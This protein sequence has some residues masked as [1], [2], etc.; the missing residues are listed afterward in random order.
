MPQVLNGEN[1]INT[2]TLEP[3]CSGCGRTQTYSGTDR[4][5]PIAMLQNST[6]RR[7]Q[8]RAHAWR[9]MGSHKN[10]SGT[11]A[12][13]DVAIAMTC[14]RVYVC[15]LQESRRQRR[16]GLVASVASRSRKRRKKPNT[17]RKKKMHQPTKSQIQTTLC[18]PST[19]KTLKITFK[20]PS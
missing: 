13:L 15:N 18:L 12:Q 2:L 16:L 4:L 6:L 14:V 10:Y 1:N 19:Q 7:M 17:T 20:T 3:T 11:G 9:A 8:C 5:K